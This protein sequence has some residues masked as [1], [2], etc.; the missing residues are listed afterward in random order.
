MPEKRLV[1]ANPIHK[2]PF[3]IQENQR[4]SPARTLLNLLQ[5][6][7][8]LQEPFFS[9]AIAADSTAFKRVFTFIIKFP[10]RQLALMFKAA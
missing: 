6:S 2:L 8:A 3:Q 7:P 5:F 10:C 9:R 4:K 1:P